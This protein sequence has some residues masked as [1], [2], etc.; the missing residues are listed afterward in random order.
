MDHYGIG[1]AVEGAARI[2][3]QSARQTGRTT[4]LIE[5]LK[6]GD[7]AVFI[8]TR[9]AKRVK[10]LCKERGVEIETIVVDPKNPL[11]I[12]DI[13]S[14]PG[15]GRCIFDHSW[16]EQFYLN[17]INDARE[18]IDTFQ[19]ETSGYGMVHIETRLRAQEVLKW[20]V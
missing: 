20:E 4:S 2:Y 10:W 3:L 12:Y 16:V 11:K 7:R 14:V 5:S 18:A 9:E 13:G 1:A 15:E 6:T 17:A 8:N 19:R